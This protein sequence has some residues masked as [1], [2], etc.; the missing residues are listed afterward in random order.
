[1][2]ATAKNPTSRKPWYYEFAAKFGFAALVAFVLVGFLV[3]SLRDAQKAQQD[4]L[5]YYQRTQ[6]QDMAQLRRAVERL[7]DRE[8]ETA[9]ATG[10]TVELLRVLVQ[11]QRGKS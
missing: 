10:K 9:A 6:A 1:M 5:T 11:L 2:T 7:A 3:S 4:T 8:S